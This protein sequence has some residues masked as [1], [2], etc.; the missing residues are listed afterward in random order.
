LELAEAIKPLERKVFNAK[1][2]GELNSDDTP[3]QIE[4]A[5]KKGVI[6]A[7]EAKQITA[8]DDKVMELIAVDDF[9]PEELTRFAPIARKKTPAIRPAKKKAKRK[10]RRSG[11]KPPSTSG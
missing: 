4:E 1:R 2:R 9:A 8:F 10:T 3:G 5:Q 11:K 6:T 7:E